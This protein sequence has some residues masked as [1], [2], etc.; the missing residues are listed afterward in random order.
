MADH[1]EVQAA[2]LRREEAIR[3]NPVA[4][5]GVAPTPEQANAMAAWGSRAL[6]VGFDWSMLQRGC[7]AAIK[8]ISRERTALPTRRPSPPHYR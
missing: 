7:A 1:P 8:D 3:L 4:L 5:G 6:F 2:A